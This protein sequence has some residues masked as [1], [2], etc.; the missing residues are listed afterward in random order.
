M[1]LEVT[2]EQIYDRL[3][4]VESKVDTIDTN[5]KE[6]VDAFQAMQ[7]AFKVLSWIA[8]AAVPILWV[9]G[10]FSTFTLFWSQI[11]KK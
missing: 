5:T 11:I 8:K 3:I 9:V 10:L 1:A 2:H 7:G 4:A 6:L